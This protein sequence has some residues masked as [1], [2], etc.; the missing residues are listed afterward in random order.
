M[1]AKLSPTRPSYSSFFFCF[2]FPRVGIKRCIE[3]DSP[4]LRSPL[5][6]RYLISWVSFCSLCGLRSSVERDSPAFRSPLWS[7]R[8]IFFHILAILRLGLTMGWVFGVFLVCVWRNRKGESSGYLEIVETRHFEGWLDE[9]LEAE[10]FSFCN[11]GSSYLG[12]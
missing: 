11:S 1:P 12:W 3:R 10:R 2:F 8:L 4:A 9:S 6:R 7:A 5:R